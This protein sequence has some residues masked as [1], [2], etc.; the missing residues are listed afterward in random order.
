MELRRKSCWHGPLVAALVLAATATSARAGGRLGFTGGVSQIEGA[1]G[2]GLVPWA[3]IAGLDTR[4][5][6]GA[7]AFATYVH[8]GDFSLRSAGAAAGI[9]D[10]LE[11]SAAVQRFDAGSVV[12]GTTLGQD[13]F[14]AKLRLAGDA[15]FDPD[16]L[17]PQI[18]VGALYKRTRDYSSIPRAVGAATGSDVEWYLAATKLY[19]DAIAGRNLLVDLTVRRTRA[20]Q[21]GL[22][23]FGGP[24]GG[25]RLEPEGSVGV[26]L[27]DDLVLGGEYRRKTGSLGAFDER[28]AGDVFL[29][30]GPRRQLTVTA[31]WVDLG[32][33]AGKPAQRGLYLSLWLGI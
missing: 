27:S 28:A 12:A 11:L 30:W 13:V 25:Y 9:D 4:D 2:G 6:V 1:A 19:F 32:P 3:L 31:A 8:T 24:T 22:L 29:A 33:I 16:R 10:R 7:T 5:E 23:G 15:V 20:N 18:A 21:Y 14:G 17:M 26:F